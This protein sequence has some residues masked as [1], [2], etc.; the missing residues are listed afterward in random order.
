M[1]LLGP[2]DKDLHLLRLG[3]ADLTAACEVDCHAVYD[4]LDHHC[5]RLAWKEHA[6]T[7][8][9]VRQL[10]HTIAGNAHARLMA[11]V[12][13]EE[14]EYDDELLHA[15][16]RGAQR[17]N[18]V[19]VCLGFFLDKECRD[20]C[21]AVVED[22]FHRHRGIFDTVPHHLVECWSGRS[23]QLHAAYATLLKLR[24]LWSEYRR[25]IAV[26]PMA[27]ETVRKVAAATGKD[28]RLLDTF[29][30]DM[31]LS[32]LNSWIAELEVG[33]RYRADNSRRLS[34]SSG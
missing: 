25:G 31:R 23:S 18:E 22:D 27:R 5:M 33:T 14:S 21:R 4:Q 8:A 19:K 28:P 1:N 34:A 17:K 24:D 16:V 20:I 3:L 12:P 26:D 13:N 32:L 7:N 10:L 30:L 11:A 29:V 15:L 6:R 2:T 9:P